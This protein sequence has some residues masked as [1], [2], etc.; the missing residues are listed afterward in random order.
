MVNPL[1][2]EV[3]REALETVLVALRHAYL[4]ARVTPAYWAL[5]QAL[6]TR[7]RPAGHPGADLRR[8]PLCGDPKDDDGYPTCNRSDCIATY[9]E[10]QRAS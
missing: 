6:E 5:E 2:V 7:G 4:G 10:A 8:C 1:T 3:P 9:R